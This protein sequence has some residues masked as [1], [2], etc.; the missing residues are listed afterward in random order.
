MS[1]DQI[2]AVV[3]VA[4]EGSVRRAAER[5]HTTQPP[6]SRQIA[7][8]ESELGARLFE[9]RPRGMALNDRGH[10]F[11]ATARRVLAAVDELKASA[12]SP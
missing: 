10:A 11:V 9:R 3:V 6:L 7:A 4:E 12:R 8:L 5:L 1:L 2:R